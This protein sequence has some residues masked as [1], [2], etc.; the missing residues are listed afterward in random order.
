MSVMGL[1]PLQGGRITA[2][3]IAFDGQELTGRCRKKLTASC[4]EAG[5][6]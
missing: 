6:G 3:S 2:G 1:L 4:G 5:S